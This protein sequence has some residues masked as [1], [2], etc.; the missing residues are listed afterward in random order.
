MR[1]P[2]TPLICA[3]NLAALL[4]L[5]SC[6]GLL[7][8]PGSKAATSAPPSPSQ[9][10]VRRIVQLDLGR[11]AHFAHCIEPACPTPTRKTLAVAAIPPAAQVLPAST[12]ASDEAPPPSERGAPHA[13]Q[14]IRA[15]VLTL[16]FTTGSTALTAQHRS[17]L[18]QAA[19]ALSRADRIL[20][21]GRTDNVGPTGPN[22]SIALS[23]ASKVRDHL[24]RM[25]TRLTQDIRIDARGLCCYAA[26]NDTAD[27]RAKNR[28]VEVVFTPSMEVAP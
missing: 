11:E 23:R 7:E 13:P 5:S 21:V 18:N 24:M 2:Q 6:G 9:P 25:R 3:V 12:S 16:L 4:G 14:S 8:L 15:Q 19:A 22:E 17:Q 28:R 1:R 27:G 20:V 10:L 26:P